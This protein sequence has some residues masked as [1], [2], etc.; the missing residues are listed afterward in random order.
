MLKRSVGYA[1]TSDYVDDPAAASRAGS[2]GLDAVALAASYHATPAGAPLHPDHR[3][4]EAE[5][6]ACHV[7]IRESA[8][9]GRRLVPVAPTWDPRGESFDD[10]HRQLTAEGHHRLR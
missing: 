6:A 3:V 7:P 2:P 10:A 8:W 9:R 1:Y 4:F 5:T